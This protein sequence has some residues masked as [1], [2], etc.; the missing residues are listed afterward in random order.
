MSPEL[1]W[2]GDLTKDIQMAAGALLLKL[3]STCQG[4]KDKKGDLDPAAPLW[5]NTVLRYN[6]GGAK[7]KAYADAVWK[8]YT[9]G[10]NPYKPGEK[11]W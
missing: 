9:Q 4:L 6:G 8:L 3:C 7:A 11:L 10:I 1:R 2:S 5:K